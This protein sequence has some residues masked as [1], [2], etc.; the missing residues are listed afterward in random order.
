MRIPRWIK[1][2]AALTFL[3]ASAEAAPK[4]E[5]VF[6]FIGGNNLAGRT[7]QP[8]T[9]EK[10]PDNVVLY[11]GD[12][13]VKAEEEK[14]PGAD[15]PCRGERRA[16]FGFNRFST[17]DDGACALHGFGPALAAALHQAQPD[18]EFGLVFQGREN[19][20]WATFER[21]YL[22]PSLTRLREATHG[23]APGGVVIQLGEKEIAEQSSASPA[24]IAKLI[25]TVRKVLGPVPVF[26]VQSP[27]YA[28]CDWVATPND[29]QWRACGVEAA[30]AKPWMGPASA[31]ANAVLNTL[32]ATPDVHVV[33]AAETVVTD[34]KVEVGR[35]LRTT[36]SINAQ[37]LLGRRI[38]ET[39]LAARAKTAIANG[40]TPSHA[41]AKTP[42]TPDCRKLLHIKNP[43][44]LAAQDLI[45]L[46]HRGRW[47]LTADAPPENSPAALKAALE[48]D[49]MAEIDYT[50]IDKGNPAS[51]ASLP[52][53]SHEY[54]IFRTTDAE[55]PDRK[56][57]LFNLKSTD[58]LKK[59]YLRRRNGDVSG[60]QFSTLG[61]VREQYF[62]KGLIFADLKQE[63][64]SDQAEFLENWTQLLL[65]MLVYSDTGDC[66]VTCQ[67]DGNLVVKTAFTPSYIRWMVEQVSPDIAAHL[68]PD[69][70]KMVNW[71]P[72]VA[73]DSEYRTRKAA[74][75]DKGVPTPGLFPQ[76]WV[77]S[78]A[79]FVDAWLAE[80]T[81]ITAFEVNYKRADDER[82]HGF[83]RGGRS[84]FNIL[85]YIRQQA[86]YRGGVFAEE[87]VGPA[88]IV[89]RWAT[90]SFKDT[91]GDLRGDPAY[92]AL[93]L[94]YG[95]FIVVTTDRPD[96]WRQIA[97]A[98]APRPDAKPRP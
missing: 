70:F 8:T 59:F 87:P 83:D 19:E 54:V 22:A 94:P 51:S 72:Q 36:F 44:W 90:W 73:S 18:T 69:W 75:H 24:A 40:F 43:D 35:D 64:D 6:L 50:P 17:I 74:Y 38:A 5:N 85:D 81:T 41:C 98:Y 21:T 4:P 89:N 32:G 76:D 92:E 48:T 58:A 20:T 46:P 67:I 15:Q 52:V 28:D 79:D 62:Q 53:N 29:P 7:D 42:G 1:L 66:R 78:S 65:A 39:I 56:I 12:H 2:A 86:G 57:I 3:P 9:P 55:G 91:A 49:G 26:L 16:R 10:A 13:W 82:R 25:E 97:D 14:S 88:G 71:T 45:I 68:P 61:D 63:T 84:Y 34:M 37:A 47:G 93:T 33:S 60:E 96:V 95:Q 23:A 11:A 31:R 80:R 30:N 77:E 27:Y